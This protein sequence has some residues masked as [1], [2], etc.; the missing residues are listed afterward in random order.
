[1]GGDKIV[2]RHSF[3]LKICTSAIVSGA[4]VMV[5]EIIATKIL[6]PFLGSS[7]FTWIGVIS[8]MMAA[9]SLGYFLGGKLA[10]RKP[11]SSYVAFIFILSGLFI[12]L[13]PLIS[14]PVLELS[15]YLGIMYGPILASILLFS[16][17]S[18][19][20][21]MISPYLIKLSAKQLK[22]IGEIS[23]NIY[24]ISTVGSIMGTL[25]T[26]FYIIPNLGIKTTLFSLSMI[27][28]ANGVLFL[29]KRKLLPLVLGLILNSAVPQ[30]VNFKP[31][32]TQLMLY[33]NY[34]PYQY[35]RVVDSTEK[36]TRTLSVGY[37]AQARISLN[38]TDPLLGYPR[39]QK[40]I[41]ALNPNIK[42]AFF[43]GLGA[44]AMPKDMH[45]KTDANITVVEIDPTVVEVAKRFFNFS[46]DAKM[47]VEIG[48]GRI[49]LRNSNEMYDYIV[50]DAYLAPIPPFHLTT[51]EFVKELKSHLNP[52]G[53]VFINIIS[54]T[55]GPKAALFRSILKTYKNSFKNIYIFPLEMMNHTVRNNIVILATDADYGDKTQLASLVGRQ[56][57]NATAEL[58]NH[59]Y[60]G[61]IDTS[62]DVL[63]TDD[64][65]PVDIL[66]VRA[67]S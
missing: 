41:Y 5:L 47:R 48:D 64:F 39:Y 26:G 30:L 24:A 36:N 53:I 32:S 15:S 19:L 44:G 42:K 66:G 10:D 8:V 37:G 45:E 7:I 27:L 59:Y 9:L 31:S 51:A 28:I 3:T 23:G 52:G 56:S 21:A 13:I 58:V 18:V 46:E 33:E 6:E 2:S 11:E 43:I 60:E 29:R 50:V 16:I 4:A 12:A 34:S 20:L 61:T 65:C 17:P 62:S 63:F 40:L 54:P 22:I 25:L 55:E 1:M 35:M 49:L 67:L 57:D 14:Y 38:P